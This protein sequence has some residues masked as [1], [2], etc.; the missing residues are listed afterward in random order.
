MGPESAYLLVTIASVIG[1]FV[2]AAYKLVLRYLWRKRQ[3]TAIED[4]VEDL[5]GVRGPDAR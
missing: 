3:I 4:Q 1:T 2:P 5:P